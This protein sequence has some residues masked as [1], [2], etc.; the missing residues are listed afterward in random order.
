MLSIGIVV[1]FHSPVPYNQ[2]EL[3]TLLPF[4]QTVTSTE[5]RPIKYFFEKIFLKAEIIPLAPHR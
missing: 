5:N 1:G 4:Q 3:P 2:V